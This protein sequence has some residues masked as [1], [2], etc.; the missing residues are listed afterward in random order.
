MC[1]YASLKFGCVF[2][3]RREKERKKER[4][5]REPFGC[6]QQQIFIGE[7]WLQKRGWG[8]QMKSR[9]RKASSL[10]AWPF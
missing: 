3:K 9:D 10:P 8:T 2:K 6:E 7:V 4:K 5:K 1:F